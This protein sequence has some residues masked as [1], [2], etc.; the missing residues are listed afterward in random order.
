MRDANYYLWQTPHAIV[1]AGSYHFDSYMFEICNTKD[2]HFTLIECD[3]NFVKM[4]IDN[5]ILVSLLFT[6]ERETHRVG[7]STFGR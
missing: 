2:V 1:S 7:A 5:K 4:R 6:L 3:V